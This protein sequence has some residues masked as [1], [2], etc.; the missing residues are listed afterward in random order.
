M[1]C[2]S[3]KGQGP[4]LHSKENIQQLFAAQN[5]R[6]LDLLIQDEYVIVLGVECPKIFL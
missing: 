5:I 6:M 2:K 3:R 1:Y 4:R